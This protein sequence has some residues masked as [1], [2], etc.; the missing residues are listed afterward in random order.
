MLHRRLRAHADEVRVRA[1]RGHKLPAANDVEIFN[2][3]GRRRFALPLI[4]D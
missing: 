1:L 2:E 3:S 4:S